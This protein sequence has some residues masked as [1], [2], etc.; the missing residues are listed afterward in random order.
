MHIKI[1]YGL[2]PTQN[3]SKKGMIRLKVQAISLKSMSQ[4][5]ITSSKEILKR[6]NPRQK[7]SQENERGLC[8]YCHKPKKR[9]GR[10]FV[11]ACTGK[12]ITLPNGKSIKRNFKNSFTCQE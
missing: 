11:C 6:Y 10:M 9:M 1:A 5:I 7:M 2:L 3:K 4:Q 12:D 8:P